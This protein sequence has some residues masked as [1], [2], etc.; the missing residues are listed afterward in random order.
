M[1]HTLRAAAPLK[2]SAALAMRSGEFTQIRRI[3]VAR[4]HDGE[5]VGRHPIEHPVRSHDPAESNGGI[6]WRL[7]QRDALGDPRSKVIPAS[8]LGKPD[9]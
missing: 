1:Q 7:M 9:V 8:G 6:V 3:G 4:D 5:V 2:R